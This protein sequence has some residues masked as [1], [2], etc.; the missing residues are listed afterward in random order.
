M[1]GGVGALLAPRHRDRRLTPGELALVGVATH[2]L[3]RIITRDWVTI[4]LRAPFTR[5]V[6]SSGS[7]EVDEESRGTGLRKAIGDLLTCNYCT[8]PWVAG[9]LVASMSFA[10]KVTRTISSVFAT[11]ALSDF[12][13][14]LY[15]NLRATR[16]LETAESSR[17]EHRADG[18]APAQST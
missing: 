13:H 2:K 17:L 6:A 18:G 16:K 14:E 5:F 8:G 9:A 11:V 7:G 10:P 1:F 4:P 15:E 3:T 12:L